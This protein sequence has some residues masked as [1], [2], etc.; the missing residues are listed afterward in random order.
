MAVPDLRVERV[1]RDDDRADRVAHADGGAHG[2]TCC[3]R[4]SRDGA[5]AWW[6]CIAMPAAPRM[7]L[8]RIIASAADWIP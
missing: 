4:E 8:L 1:V 7:M 5:P 6:G 3:A 2:E